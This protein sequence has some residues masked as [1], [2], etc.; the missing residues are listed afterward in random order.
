MVVL[1]GED[2]VK[3]RVMKLMDEKEKIVA[4]IYNQRA[5]LEANHVGMD[6]PLVDADGFPRND[7]DVYKVRHA[8]HRIICLQNDHKNIMKKIE[9]GLE[10]VHSNLIANPNA[11]QPA[12]SNRHEA[13]NG[14]ASSSNENSSSVQESFAIVGLVDNGSPADLG[15]LCTKDEILQFGSVTHSNFTDIT[16]I[17]SVV[18]HS[19]GQNVSVIVKRQQ[20]VINLTVV[21]QAW[22]KPGLL[23]CHI[24]R[25]N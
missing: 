10:E 24:Q 18:S 1:T 13:S 4:E 6:E 14:Q 8:R 19:V 12:P 15:G 3:S 7:I 23:G 5:I 20:H 2:P 16:Q 17:H 21:P 9:K 22:S 11:A 25:K